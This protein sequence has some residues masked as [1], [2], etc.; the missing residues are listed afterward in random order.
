MKEKTIPLL[1]GAIDSLP[2]PQV[3]LQA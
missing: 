2:W 3:R 1:H